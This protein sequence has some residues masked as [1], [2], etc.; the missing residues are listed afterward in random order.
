[1]KTFFLNTENSSKLGDTT[2]ANMIRTAGKTH[3]W[4]ERTSE[5]DTI[6]IHFMSDRI[7]HPQATFKQDNLISIFVEYDVSA[8]Y[9]ILRT[10]T[11]LNLVPESAKAWHAGGSIM[12]EP[13][14]RTGVNDFSIGIELAG[15]ENHPFTPNQYKSLNRLIMS[16]KNRHTITSILGHEDISGERAVSMGIRQDVKIDPGPQFKWSFIGNKLFKFNPESTLKRYV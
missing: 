12:P 11:V 4:G 16:I 15:S 3:L 9:L 1:M 8:H 2:V 6:V 13:D 14:N 7:R 10:G 5:I